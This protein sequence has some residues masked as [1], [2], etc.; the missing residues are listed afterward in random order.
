VRGGP[1]ICGL[2][3][4][5]VAK[6]R[7]IL[8]E[9]PWFA[10]DLDD[11]LHEFRKASGKATSAA[12]RRIEEAYDVSLKSLKAAYSSILSRSTANAFTD[13]K[14]SNDY[15]KE[16]FA[17]VPNEFA[18]DFSEEFLVGLVEAYKSALEEALEAKCGAMDLL[19]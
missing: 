1:A 13:G 10:F 3:G 19:A 2:L 16:R 12:L 4:E 14:T 15:R 5:E 7:Q 11:T 6:L 17:A 8:L 18:L 9:K